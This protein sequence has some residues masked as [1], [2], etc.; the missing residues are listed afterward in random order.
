M[1]PAKY[2]LILTVLGSFVACQQSDDFSSKT[3][4]DSLNLESTE[5]VE[6]YSL[7]NKMDTSDDS[8]NVEIEL[9]RKS[10]SSF[11]LM[12]SLE[13]FGESWI[14]SPDA[15]NYPYHSLQ[16]HLEENNQIQKVDSLKSIAEPYWLDDLPGEKPYPVIMKKG[17]LLHDFMIENNHDC[18]VQ[19]HLFF[20]LEPICNPTYIKFRIVQE[21][22]ELRVEKTSQLNS[23]EEIQ[24]SPV[25]KPGI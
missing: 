7:Q 19:G 24:K 2:T 5:P 17:L 20:V 3:E 22:R 14:I 8:V 23:L 9:N 1:W 21:K 13:L 6:T 12:F 25:E 16:L 18:E 10:T 15:W 11:S 4:V